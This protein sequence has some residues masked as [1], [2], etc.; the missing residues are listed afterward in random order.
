MSTLLLGGKL[1][2]APIKQNIGVSTSRI[3]RGWQDGM[4]RTEYG[5]RFLRKPSMLVLAQ[6]YGPCMSTS[7][8]L[9]SSSTYI[10]PDGTDTK[11]LISSDFGEEFPNAEVVGTDISPI[12]PTWVPPNV[13]FEIDDANL[14]WTWKD[15]TFDFVHLRC[16]LGTIIDWTSFY[17]KAFR[18][19]KPGGWIEHHE[20]SAAWRCEGGE[21]PEESAMGQW[22]KV[23]SEG[24][25]KFGRSFRILQD[26]L[27]KKGMEE[28]GFVDI[29]VRD[30]KCPIGTWP[31]DPRLRET[32][33]FAKYTLDMD[34]EGTFSWPHDRTLAYFFNH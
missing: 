9:T 33:A 8:S 2:L 3:Q 26:D 16:M 11:G 27:Q 30:F 32:G 17:R 5:L 14:E 19:C 34:F 21:I 15:N 28:A 24:G 25:K 22:E 12:Q 29:V 7:I 10:A 31:Q 4:Q 13:R 18:C 23:F 1:F 20:E 6:E